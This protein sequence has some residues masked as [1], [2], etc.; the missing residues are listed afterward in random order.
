M[1][2]SLAA[3]KESPE[4]VA[5]TQ[6]QTPRQPRIMRLDRCGCRRLLYAHHARAKHMRPDLGKGSV[7][8]R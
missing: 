1:V 3:Q 2:Q 7:T 8:A 4:T 6:R 5:F